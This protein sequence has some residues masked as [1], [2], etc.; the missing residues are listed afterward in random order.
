MNLSIVYLFLDDAHELC[1]KDLSE[2]VISRLNKRLHVDEVARTQIYQ[3]FGIDITPSFRIGSAYEIGLQNIDIFNLFPDTPVKVLKEVFEA[4]QLYD[5]I[6]LL[7]EGKPRTRRSLRPA[8]SL[9]GIEKLR[10]RAGRPTSYHS[11]AAVL[12]I[13]ASEENSSTEG[14]G[15]FFKGLN[16]KSEVTVIQYREMLNTYRDLYYLEAGI[17]LERSMATSRER[18]ETKKRQMEEEEREKEKVRSAVSAVTER[19][20][21]NQGW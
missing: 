2:E 20:I 3:S 9:Q 19:W 14:I 16:V 11:S 1:L 4:L 18:T 6:D 7:E 5:L 10:D 12:I 8:L 15:N 13:D 17:T 21:T